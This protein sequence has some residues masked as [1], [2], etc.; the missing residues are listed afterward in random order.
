MS[1]LAFVAVGLP[2]L[3]FLV[4]SRGTTGA[5]FGMVAGM[6][7]SMAILLPLTFTA[8]SLRPTE[9]G[10]ALARPIACAGAVSAALLVSLPAAEALG[11]GAAFGLVAAVGAGTFVVAVALFGRPVVVPLWGSLRR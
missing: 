2:A 7:A 1:G 4:P 8:L 6:C 5:A 11:S 10:R 9:L 3:L